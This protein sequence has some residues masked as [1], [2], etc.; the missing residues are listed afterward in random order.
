MDEQQQRRILSWLEEDS[1]DIRGG[2]DEENETGMFS[3]Q[4]SE[5]DTDSEQECDDDLHQVFSNYDESLEMPN[6][7]HL[8][9]ELVNES[10]EVLESLRS[11][12]EMKNH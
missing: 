6:E 1:D 11:V 12:M 9:L 8:R 2:H 5:H 10:M 4:V 3:D 7:K